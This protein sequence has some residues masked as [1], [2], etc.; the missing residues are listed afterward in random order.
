MRRSLFLGTVLL[1]RNRGRGRGRGCAE[2]IPGLWAGP[3]CRAS[4]FVEMCESKKEECKLTGT[5]MEGYFSAFNALNRDTFDILPW[6][7]PEL[8]AAVHL[9][10][11]QAEPGR[12]GAGGRQRADPQAAGA[13]RGSRPPRIG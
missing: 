3:R 12:A 9:Q 6:Q 13:E 11:L 2:P 7:P 5:W 8:M 1:H 10:R 4:A